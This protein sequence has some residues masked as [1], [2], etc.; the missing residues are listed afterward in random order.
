MGLKTLFVTHKPTAIK[1]A[2]VIIAV[3]VFGFSLVS[4]VNSQNARDQ[5]TQNSQSVVENHTETLNEIKQAVADLKASNAADHT[6][7]VQ[8]IN[9]VLVG[10]T[11]SS[12]PAQAQATYQTCLVA[13][14]VTTNP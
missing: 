1:V 5:Q 3:A 4:F 6:Q 11:D 14:G 12:S 8:Y 9:C 13:A 2:L 10:I 7:T